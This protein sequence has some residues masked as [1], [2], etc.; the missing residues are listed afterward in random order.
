MSEPEAGHA[1]LDLALNRPGGDGR[2]HGVAAGLQH[3]HADF[4]GQRMPGRHHALRAHHGGPPAGGL[5]VGNLRDDE[6]PGP[7]RRVV[8]VSCHLLVENEARTSRPEGVE[9][10]EKLATP[11]KS[12]TS[13]N[14]TVTGPVTIGGHDRRG[15][16]R[17]HAHHRRARAH[18]RGVPG[19]RRDDAGPGVGSEAGRRAGAGGAGADDRAKPSACSPTW[20]RW[21]WRSRA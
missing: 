8:D 21:K 9:S 11:V 19:L 12:A 1:R 15:A 20:V 7:A 16:G 3:P 14:V 17:G 10:M 5:R 13:P 4:G 2:V 18:R 6:P